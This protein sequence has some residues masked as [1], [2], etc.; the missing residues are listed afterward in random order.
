MIENISRIANKM[1]GSE[2]NVSPEL[3]DT[4]LRLYKGVYP[5]VSGLVAW[6]ENCEWQSSLPLGAVP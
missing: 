5:N 4:G 2:G 1:N 3:E 6:S